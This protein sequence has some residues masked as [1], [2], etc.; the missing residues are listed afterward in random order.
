MANNALAIGFG[1]NWGLAMKGAHMFMSA[2][3][4]V[5]RARRVSRLVRAIPSGNVTAT[6]AEAGGFLDPI[7]MFEEI[8]TTEALDDRSFRGVEAVTYMLQGRLR[9]GGSYGHG[10][11]EEGGVLWLTAGRGV[12]HAQAPLPSND[13]VRGARLRLAASTA[14]GAATPSH[15]D[16]P[17]E[18]IPAV[19]FKSAEVRMLA[20]QFHGLIGPIMPAARPFIADVQ[21]KREGEVA[22]DIP[23]G[24]QGLV[25]VFEGG[26]AIEQTL[27]NPG[28]AAVLEDG[29]LLNL[30][31]GGDGARALVVMARPLRQPI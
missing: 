13:G 30:V 25:Y 17:A 14:E 31:A 21:L 16:I 11:V 28:Q 2:Y 12:T 9:H 18:D 27:V 19:I 26:V 6:M 8:S 15:R 24:Y 1:S 7:L 23:E 3:P 10:E 4:Q 20:G 5:H 22:L 29:N